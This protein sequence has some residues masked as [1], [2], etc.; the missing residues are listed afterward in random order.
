VPQPVDNV[1]DIGFA[2]VDH[3]RFERTGIPE[4]VFCEGKTPAQAAAI[5]STLAAKSGF[6]LATR[7]NLRHQKAIVRKNPK[8]IA[9][10]QARAVSLGGPIYPKEHSRYTVIVTAGTGDIPVAEEARVTLEF[11]GIRVE[12]LYDVGVAGIDRL[13]SH[14]SLL[15]KASAIISVAGMDSACPVVT[16]S[17]ARCLV[18]GVATS[19]GYGVGH[20]GKAALYTILN[21]C[22]PGMVAVNI[23]NGFG[24]ACAVVRA[25]KYHQP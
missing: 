12:K 23:D 16:S 6:A 22:V 8:A 20:G 10:K 21:A 9:Y 2:T 18:V 15:E 4:V 11:F 19:I 17:L 5:F 25:L 1:E 24:A 3:G 7:A 14:R 13:F